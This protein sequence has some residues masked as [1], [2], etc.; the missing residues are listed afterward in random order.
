MNLPVHA[1]SKEADAIT[2]GSSHNVLT[3]Y[4]LVPSDELM[5][6]PTRSGRTLNLNTL[7]SVDT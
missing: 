6:Q 4:N 2:H 1:N 3:C 7:E 5:A